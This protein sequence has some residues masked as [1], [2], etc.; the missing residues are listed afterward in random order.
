MNQRDKGNF[1]RA[2]TKKALN[3]ALEVSLDIWTPFAVRAFQRPVTTKKPAAGTKGPP[4][5]FPH[6]S[7][8]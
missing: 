5:H 7:G 2:S 4:S 6:L 1:F 3:L 8:D